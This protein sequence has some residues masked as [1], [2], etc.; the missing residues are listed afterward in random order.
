MRTTAGRLA[1]AGTVAL[2]AACSRNPQP[3]VATPPVPT[4]TDALRAQ[5]HRDSL[6]AAAR[7][8]SIWRAQ[9][10][11][12]HADSVRAAVMSETVDSAKDVT[13]TGLAA[14]AA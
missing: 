13:N 12:S 8:D 2:L 1:V 3:V 14:A 7:A 4:A 6:L 5:M 11:E 10:A 9:K